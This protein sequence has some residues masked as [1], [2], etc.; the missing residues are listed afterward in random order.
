M[1]LPEALP[2]FAKFDIDFNIY[3][4]IYIHMY[5]FVYE[6]SQFKSSGNIRLSLDMIYMIS[7][8]FAENFG[9]P[10]GWSQHGLR[11]F[12]KAQLHELNGADSQ[13]IWYI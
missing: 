5:I 11:H 2:Y 12:L 9:V 3:I 7:L 1:N 10:S 6:F 13:K 8:D 4:Y